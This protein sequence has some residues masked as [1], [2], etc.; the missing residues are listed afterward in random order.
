MTALAYLKDELD[1][2]ARADLLRSR[3][4]SLPPGTLVLCSNDYLGFASQPLDAAPGD[5][6]GAGA[7]RLIS[8]SHP[9]HELL[10]ADLARWVG[11]ES[12]LL[13]SSGYAANVGVLSALCSREDFVVS[14]ALNHASI[15]DGCRLSR[16]HVHIAAHR[17]C[18]AV[19]HALA[20]AESRAAR[21]RFVVTEAYFS[22]DGDSPDL[23]KLRA[24]CDAHDAALIVDEAHSLGV[25]GPAGGGLARAAGI[26]PD[27]FVGTLGKAV[28]MQGAFVAGTANL[29]AWLWNR[30]RSFVF[31]TAPSPA[32]ST[33][34]IDRIARVEAA[35]REREHLSEI[36][37]RV[38]AVLTASGAQLADGSH[39]P[40]LPWLV[41]N[42]TAA[43]ELSRQLLERGL[44]V[45][46]IRPPTV[47][48]NS[49]R[50]R[51]T[52][53][54][55]LSASDVDRIAD[56]VATVARAH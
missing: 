2:L 17:D 6:S 21:R 23:A 10:E 46:A 11:L 18:S 4:P 51:I 5:A 3:Q 56:V 32:M 12:A 16:A 27:V 41:G 39:G 49:A 50:L 52:L 42:S 45:P 14:D 22:M 37:A 25:F 40:I 29:R 44:Y 19:A 30:A 15:I 1:R 33:A 28:G 26:V 36:C 31:S 35:D 43:L 38:R 48:A 20:L 54:A 13:F 24:I 8:G 47:P 34:I 9:A 7:S 55:S 53:Q